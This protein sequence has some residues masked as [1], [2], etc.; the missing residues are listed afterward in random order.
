MTIQKIQ[1]PTT[2]YDKTRKPIK[3]IV[4]HWIVGNLASADA[5]FKKQNSTSAHYAVEDDVIHQYVDEGHTAYAVGNYAR[6]QETISIEHSAT[7]DRPATDKTYETSAQL[8]REICERHNIPI[9]REHIIKHSEVKATQCPGTM[10]LD[11]LITLARQGVKNS[12]AVDSGTFEQLV[13]KSSEYDKFVA[14]GYPHVEDVIQKV[15]EKDTTIQNLTKD[16]NTCEVQVGKLLD[17]VQKINE[18]DKNTSSELLDAQHALQPLKNEALAVRRSLK[19][20]DEV[21]TQTLLK[22]IEVLRKAKTTKAQVKDW[23]FIEKLRILFG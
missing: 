6:N 2:N 11:R 1:I 3:Q 9:D 16:I 18:E 8:I 13:T 4:I 15:T 21:D 5:V 7:P 19:L 17:D 14:G 12:V 22:T 10:D 20:M 23:P